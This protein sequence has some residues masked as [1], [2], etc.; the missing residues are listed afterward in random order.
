MKAQGETSGSYSSCWHMTIARDDSKPRNRP[1]RRARSQTERATFTIVS[2]NFG[3]AIREIAHSDKA[4]IARPEAIGAFLED[5]SGTG[6]LSSYPL[7]AGF[8]EVSK[9]APAAVPSFKIEDLV[10]SYHANAQFYYTPTVSTA[11]Y[12]LQA[13]WHGRWKEQLCAS[14]QGMAVCTKRGATLLDPEANATG[15]GVGGPPLFRGMVLNLPVVVFR[16]K[17]EVLPHSD[18]WIHHVVELDSDRIAVQFRHTRYLGSRDT[19][20]RTAT[21]HRVLLEGPNKLEFVFIN[22]HLTTLREEDRPDA[23][24]LS[25][26]RLARTTR[27]PTGDAQFLRHLQ[28]SEICDFILYVYSSFQL[29]VVVAGD[30]NTTANA[31]ELKRFMKAAFLKP[32]FRSEECWACHQRPGQQMKDYYSHERYKTVLTEDELSFRKITGEEPNI[33]S[34]PENCSNCNSPLFTHKR[35]FGLIDNILFTESLPTGMALKATLRLDDTGD[36]AGIGTKTYFSD[37]FPVWAAF[38]VI[39]TADHPRAF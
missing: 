28:L 12:P 23:S 4:V 9:T 21:A 6:R 1:K 3:G 7:I 32:V 35:N 25:T 11:L 16:D 36:G 33:I 26:P 19:E 22:V 34:V 27:V 14:E 18:R 15:S 20:P 5:P 24:G 30:F 2:A 10:G 31:P 17:A 8:Q 29:P 38:R 39:P 37:H 13:K